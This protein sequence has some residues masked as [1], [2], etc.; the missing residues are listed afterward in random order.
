MM[1]PDRTVARTSFVAHGPN[2]YSAMFR[3]GSRK[4]F[5]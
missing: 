1:V 4:L 3:V 5:V 2:D